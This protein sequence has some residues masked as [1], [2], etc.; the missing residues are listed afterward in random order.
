MIVLGNETRW[1]TCNWVQYAIAGRWAINKPAQRPGL[2]KSIRDPNWLLLNPLNV[3]MT[4]RE[5]LLAHS[6]EVEVERLQPA[7]AK[8]VQQVEVETSKKAGY[9]L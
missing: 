7:G 3:E 1:K 8:Q 9:V 6:V 2:W 5:I 4:P